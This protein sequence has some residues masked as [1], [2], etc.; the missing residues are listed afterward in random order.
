M[1]RTITSVET[2]LMPSFTMCVAMHSPT[3]SSSF[4]SV[5]WLF[6]YSIICC[7]HNMQ[8]C[9]KRQHRKVQIYEERY[10]A[11]RYIS[12][13]LVWRVTS[14]VYKTFNSLQYYSSGVFFFFFFFV[15]K[16]PF[17][18]CVWILCAKTNIAAQTN[19]IYLANK[20]WADREIVWLLLVETA[21]PEPSM[22]H[23]R[24]AFIW[25]IGDSYDSNVASVYL[26]KTASDLK[27][28]F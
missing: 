28:H 24:H 16:L 10:T 17:P 19:L 15:I 1:F 11:P 20:L 13:H 12:S 6:T 2:V 25:L 18:L 26:V 8:C 7:R 3:I 27:L 14:K 5:I 22:Y 4:T 23:L 21:A 9:P